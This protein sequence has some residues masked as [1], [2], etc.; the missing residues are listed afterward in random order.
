MRR[1]SVAAACPGPL[2]VALLVLS[3]CTRFPTDAVLPRAVPDRRRHGTA[4]VCGPAR[5]HPGGGPGDGALLSGPR[6]RLSPGRAAP[7]WSWPISING[8][9]RCRTPSPGCWRRTCPS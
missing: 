1:L 9:R 6:R 8:R 2:G 7:S 4:G 5:P 3:G